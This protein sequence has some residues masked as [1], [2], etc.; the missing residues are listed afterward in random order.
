[1]PAVIAWTSTSFALVMINA[2]KRVIS[3]MSPLN[4]ISPAP[5]V[6]VKSKSPSTVFERVRSL[7]PELRVKSAVSVMGE[8]AERVPVAEILEPRETVPAPD[9]LKLVLET[10][11]DIAPI[12]KAP[13]LVIAIG[14]AVVVT[15]LLK[16]KDD[17]VRLIEPAFNVPLN[18]VGP[19][20]EAMV[21]GPEIIAFTPKST[22]AALAMVRLVNGV[23]WP[24]VPWKLTLPVPAV[25]LKAVAPS[26]EPLKVILAPV[27]VLKLLE[28]EVK[29]IGDVKLIGALFVV[30]DPPSQAAPLPV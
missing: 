12:V 29:M 19:V 22:S 13:L 30:I 28:V 7:P 21:K 1:M 3:P 6:S 25:K 17:P 14:P 2:A 10:N 27:P 20:A 11:G 24:I 23:V 8:A 9:W 15:A 5:A 16:L 26:S 4:V 18:V